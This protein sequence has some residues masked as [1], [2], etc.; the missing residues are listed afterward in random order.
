MNTHEKKKGK[1]HAH[2]YTAT[3]STAYGR[4]APSAMTGY[5][6]GALT[7]K[8]RSFVRLILH[9]ST[10]FGRYEITDESGTVVSS[11]DVKW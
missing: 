9:D 7:L 5:N 8:V 4:R 6:L 3:W 10:D 11:G 2:L 1:T